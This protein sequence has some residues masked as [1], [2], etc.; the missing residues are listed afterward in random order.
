M[1]ERKAVRTVA[2]MTFATLFSKFLGALR[3]ALFSAPFGTGSE[4]VA[5]TAAQRLPLSFFDI[6]F[7]AAITGCFIPAYNSFSTNN[8]SKK[9]DSFTTAF[10]LVVICAT[11]LMTVMAELFAPQLISLTVRGL[12][13]DTH[14]LA[15][16]LMRIMFP[17]VIFIGSCYI[18]SGILQSKG[19]F[20]LPALV[21][22][23]SNI[24]SVVYLLH[25][26]H[27]KKRTAIIYLAVIYTVSWA[28][29]F[30]TLLLPLICR[31]K[32]YRKVPDFRSTEFKKAITGI[33]ATALSSCLVPTALLISTFFASL[34]STP[35]GASVFDYSYIIYII[36]AGTLSHGI[37]GFI[38]PSLSRLAHLDDGKEFSSAVKKALYYSVYISLPCSLFFAIISRE[39]VSVLYLRDSFTNEDAAVVSRLLGTM[40]LFIP[41]YSAG[42]ILLRAFYSKKHRVVPIIAAVTGVLITVYATLLLSYFTNKNILSAGVGYGVGQLISSLILFIFLPRIGVKITAW[43]LLYH[44]LKIIIP[45]AFSAAMMVTLYRF[46]GNN[47]FTAEALKD[48][49]VSLAVLS[50]GLVP[51]TIRYLSVKLKNMKGGSDIENKK[52]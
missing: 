22:S 9:R 24:L 50:A 17:S 6:L 20:I 35:G 12:D 37:S 13:T 41:F 30:L 32:T 39:M 38:F 48:I 21:S 18:L 33:P 43:R 34:S 2:T 42:E 47:P 40:V 23:G 5:F 7:S 4:A 16:L 15:V 11:V 52:Q 44:G 31:H 46:T 8:K 27:L 26:S 1:R 25:F 45:A 28:V 10:F 29:Q 19:R 3:N 14:A 49:L 36:A 51:Y